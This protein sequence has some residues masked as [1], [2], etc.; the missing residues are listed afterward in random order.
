MLFCWGGTLKIV[1]LPP[2]SLPNLFSKPKILMVASKAP[3]SAQTP[4]FGACRAP[5][6]PPSAAPHSLRLEA[7]WRRLVFLAHETHLDYPPVAGHAHFRG[8]ASQRVLSFLGVVSP[9]SPVLFFCCFPVVGS[10]GTILSVPT[11]GFPM[12]I[13][14][15]YRSDPWYGNWP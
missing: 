1:V 3:N 5:P 8:F 2:A 6:S 13:L 14:S 11:S 4:T 12:A 9:I 10:V 15:I 7:P